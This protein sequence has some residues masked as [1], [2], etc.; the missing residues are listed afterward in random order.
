MLSSRLSIA[1]FVTLGMSALCLA[2]AL[3]SAMPT[4]DLPG[5]AKSL[6]VSGEVINLSICVFV[7]GFGIGPMVFAPRKPISMNR[8]VPELI[9]KAFIPKCLKSSVASLST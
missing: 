4:G 5:T 3:G 1:R 6:H 9:I 8:H 2:V 7:L